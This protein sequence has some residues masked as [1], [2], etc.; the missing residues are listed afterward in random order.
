MNANDRTVDHLYLAVVGLDHKQPE[1]RE[2]CR[3]AHPKNPLAAHDLRI[4]T[5]R[6]TSALQQIC[7]LLGV[8]FILT[9]GAR[10]DSGQ[11][12]THVDPDHHRED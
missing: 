5:K 1:Y 8:C 12:G 4:G 2:P 11:V 9:V 3:P 7:Q 10:E 6:Q